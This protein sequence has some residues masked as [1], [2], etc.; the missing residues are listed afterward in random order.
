MSQ[1][2]VTCRIAKLPI[3]IGG[4]DLLFRKLDCAVINH[5]HAS[6]KQAALQAFDSARGVFIEGGRL[7][8]NSSF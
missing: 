3:S 7:Y 5:I 2:F 1:W 8:E 6:L 4:H